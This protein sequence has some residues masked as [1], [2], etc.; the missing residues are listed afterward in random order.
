MFNRFLASIGI[1]SA[2]IDTLLE[3]AHYAQGEEVKGLVRIR[4]GSVPQDISAIHLSLMTEYIRESNDHKYREQAGIARIAVSHPF[5]LE[6]GETREVPFAFRLPEDTP[7]TFRNVPVWIKT[8]LDI[9]G[10][11]DPSDHDRIEVL[12]GYET[13]VVL[14]ALDELGFR[15]RKADCEYSRRFGTRLPFVQELEFVPT[16]S[17][18]GALDELEVVFR[19]VPDGV[20][21]LLEIDRRARG[22]ASMFAEALSLDESVV[23]VSFSGREL[24]EGPSAVAQQL[25]GI[26]AR[27]AH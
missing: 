1:G 3:K 20:E 13:N 8:E 27:Y 6:A 7:L 10:A 22:L 2:T 12:P 25:K 19:P 26:I 11:V 15:L 16:A 4:G 21:L 24:A 23:R 9:R 5:K 18:R 14:E 17:F